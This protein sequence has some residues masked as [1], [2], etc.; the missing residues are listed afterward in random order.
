MIDYFDGNLSPEE[1]ALLFAFLEANP[2][3]R[4]E[5]E[6]LEDMTIKADSHSFYFKEGLKKNLPETGKINTQNIED[7]CIA[8]HEGDLNPQEKLHLKNFLAENPQWEST[9]REYG[10]LRLKADLSVEF[11][12]KVSLYTLATETGES[13]SEENIEEYLIALYEGDLSRPQQEEVKHFLVQNPKYNENKKRIALL[14]LQPDTGIVYQGKTALKKRMILPVSKNLMQRTAIAASIL[15]LL[16]LAYLFQP[17]KGNVRIN[18]QK[19]IANTDNRQIKLMT[20]VKSVAPIPEQK[21]KTTAKIQKVAPSIKETNRKEIAMEIPKKMP[22]RVIAAIPYEHAGMEIDNPEQIV[23]IMSPINIDNYETEI[24]LK[25]FS[26]KIVNQFAL[27]LGKSDRL[28]KKRLRNS[29]ENLMDV[30]VNGYNIL[31][32][33]DRGRDNLPELDATNP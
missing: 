28:S 6:G 9:F 16:G 23:A 18:A 24:H 21:P 30:A 2:D 5:A 19:R 17:E 3:I 26:A 11:S 20:G 13:I 7:Y 27:L 4:E 33:S 29:M 10:K 31:M 8:Y 12:D 25:G 22:G 14:K 32:E 1:E 15:L